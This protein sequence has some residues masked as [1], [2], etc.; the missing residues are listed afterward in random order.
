MK[1]KFIKSTI[2]LIIGGLITKLLG[3]VIKIVYTRMIGEDGI[4]LFMLVT[5]AY[6]LFITIA[7]LGLPIAISKLV[8]ENKNSKKIIFSIIPLMLILNFILVVIIFSCS[9]FIAN[10]LLKEPNSKLLLMAMALVL[11]FISLSSIIR[12]YFFG[13]QKM[14]PHTLSNI[15]EQIVKLGLIFLIIPILM[16]KGI[17]IAVSGLILLNII[18]EIVSIIVFLFFLPKNFCIKKKDIKPDINSCKEV[19]KISIPSVSS[20]F[21]GNIGFFFEPIILTNILISI[22]YSSK[23]IVREYGIYNAYSIPLLLLPSFFIAALASALVPEISKFYQQRN[24]KMVKRRFNQALGISFIIG[25]VFNIILYIYADDLLKIIYNTTSGTQYIKFLAPFFLL[26]YLEGPMISMLQAL[27][28][29]TVSMKIT[30][31]GV[32]LKL[33][34]I[35]IL[36]FLHIGIYGLVASEIINIIF[37]VILNYKEIRKVIN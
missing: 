33:L 3:F 25:L 7:Q 14:F 8:A 1:N 13:K 19:L 11:P 12:G 36:S 32:I 9:S 22:G 27:N 31:Y 17:I 28:K 35:T 29:A 18:S 20:R 16:K 37:V 10:D 4:S 15:I 2:I 21:I 23:Y 24:L 30:L 34:A 26:F 5:P 6:S